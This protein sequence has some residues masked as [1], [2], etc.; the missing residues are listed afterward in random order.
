MIR[1]HIRSNAVGYVAVFL[2]LS[3]TATALTGSNTVFTD[4]ITDEEVRAA[5]VATDAIKAAEIAPGQVRTSDLAADAVNGTKVA[6]ASLTGFDFANDSLDSS[7]VTGLNGSDVQD[8]TLA[9]SD[10]VEGT[11]GELPL[12]TVAGTG[13]STSSQG[14]PWCDPGDASFV[15]CVSFVKSLPAQGRVLLEGYGEGLRATLDGS[16]GPATGR[17]RL[18]LISGGTLEYYGDTEA[19]PSL[20]NTGFPS[21]NFY[22]VGGEFDLTAVTPPVGPGVVTLSLACNETSSNIVYQ[23]VGL[24]AV[25]IGAR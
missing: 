9:G 1:N 19:R 16:T 22:G 23:G 24:S 17:C 7:K 12:A 20:E 2:A 13:Q 15:T 18:G 14:S 4:D 3:G 11:L 25:Q 8:D 6:A 5:D 10:V 21:F